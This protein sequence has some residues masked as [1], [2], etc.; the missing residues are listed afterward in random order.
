[1]NVEEQ[2]EMMNEIKREHAQEVAEGSFDTAL[3]EFKQQD[4][5]YKDFVESNDLTDE[6]ND[7]A[8]EEYAKHY[9]N[10]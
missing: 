5:I 7:W 8:R 3:D 2:N 4:S 9:H 6:F 10:D 1:M